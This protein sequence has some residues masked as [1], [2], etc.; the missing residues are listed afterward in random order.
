MEHI[1]MEMGMFF[2]E[3]LKWARKTDKVNFLEKMVE[4][5]LGTGSMTNVNNFDFK[6]IHMIL[7]NSVYI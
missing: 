5:L 3:F 1:P 7:I 4:E 6:N 2:K